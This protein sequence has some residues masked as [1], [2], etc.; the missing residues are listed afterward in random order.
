MKTWDDCVAFHGHSCNGLAIGYQAARC[1]AELLELDFS[2]DEELLCI[3]ENDACGIDA[4]QVLLGCS[5]GKGNLLFRLRGKQVFHF[6]RRSDG[7]SLR[8]M[9]KPRPTGLSKEESFRYL[10]D[11]APA[12]LF[13]AQPSPL[14][15][16]E[17]ARIFRSYPCDGCG[18]ITASAWLRLAEDKKL[19]LDCY[20]QYSRF[21]LQ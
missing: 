7:R 15:L 3:A 9:L 14:P 19:C 12:A 10:M 21:D 11:S 4:I 18:E 20:R 5:V 1:A 6:F 8:L 13:E 2:S 16:P 17:T